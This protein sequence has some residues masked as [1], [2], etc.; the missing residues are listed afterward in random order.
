[1]KFVGL[2]RHVH[3]FGC[4]EVEPFAIGREGGEHLE[5]QAVGE[6]FVLQDFL[7]INIINDEI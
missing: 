4:T 2:H 6:S 3:R 1:M 7:V 5:I